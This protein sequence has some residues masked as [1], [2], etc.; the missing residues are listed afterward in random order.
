MIYGDLADLGRYRGMA[1]S[2]DVLIDWLDGND[3]ASLPCGSHEILGDKVYANVM[4]ATTRS[5]SEAH[6]ETHHRYHDLQIDLEGREAFRVAEGE[7][8]LVEPFNEADDFELVD[9]ERGID[10]NLDEGRF[11]IFVVGEPHMP[12]LEFPGDGARPVKKIC[13]KLIADEFFEE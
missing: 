8:T 9:V 11:A 12:T 5:A 13:F 1:R 3:P 2:L 7:T 6:Y 4:A 10:G